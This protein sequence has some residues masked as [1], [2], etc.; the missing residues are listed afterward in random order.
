MEAEWSALL[1]MP[2][3]APTNEFDRSAGTNG[4]EIGLRKDGIYLVHEDGAL[5]R[6]APPILVIAYATSN[7]NTPRESAFTVIKFLNR[8][9]RWKKEIVPSSVF[10]AL[11]G[12]LIRLLSDRGYLWPASK[13]MRTQIIAALSVERPDRHIRVTSVPGRCGRWFVLPGDESYGPKGPSRKGPLIVGHAT[14]RLGAYLRSGTL[15][16]WKRHVAKKCV[17]SSRARLAVASNFAAPNL[18]VLGLNSF[19]FNF[20]GITSGGKTLLLRMAASASGLNSD[21]GPATWD[22]T[23]AAFE[24]RALGHRDGIMPLDDIS[25]LEGDSQKVAKLMTFRLAGNRT[26]EKAGQY[27]LAQNLVEE[28]YRVIALSTSEVPLWEHLDT[29]GPRRIRG[30]EVRMIN[31]RACVS[32]MQDAFDGKRA[33]NGVGRTVE[34]RRRFV[35]KQERLARKYQGEAFRAYLAKRA[36]DP[37][38]KTTLKTY[39]T[40][41]IASAPL[42]GQQRWLGRIQRLFAAIYAGAAQAIDYNVLPWTKKATL[43]AIRAC[44]DD[45]MEQLIANSAD[46]TDRALRSQRSDQSLLAEFKQR[47]R[48]ARFVRLERNRRKSKGL[49]VQLKNADGI[50]RP[51]QPHKCECFLFGAA[52]NAWFPEVVERQ[53]LAKLLFSLRIIKKGRRPDTNTKQV[54]IAELGT[55][56]PC[57]GLLRKRL[58]ALSTNPEGGSRL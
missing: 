23:P 2:M 21:A 14:V 4:G 58:K 13:I 19:G 6:I 51:T 24:Q 30:E 7:P 34:Q 26:K 49:L 11:P 43:S 9:K 36:Q 47:V 32:D 44:M 20:S 27:V 45:A 28:D 56:I 37:N 33:R 48:D 50:I 54:M 29:H 12:E 31:V 46:G 35:E 15:D 18:G 38:A 52:L 3:I 57:Y 39:M 41:Y 1:E 17:H 22:G 55:K 10:T 53:Q 8:R 42:P 16:D 40:D 25:H 5:N